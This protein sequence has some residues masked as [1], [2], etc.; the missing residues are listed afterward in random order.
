MDV[1]RICVYGSSSQ[2]T[3]AS[4][5]REAGLLGKSGPGKALSTQA[6]GNCHAGGADSTELMGVLR[7]HN[8]R[9][10]CG[11]LWL[12]LLS[13]SLCRSV[14][15]LHDSSA[16][17][18]KLLPV[19]V[20]LIR[21]CGTVLTCRDCVTGGALAEHGHVCVNGYEHMLVL[22]VCCPFFYIK[23]YHALARLYS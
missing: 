19:A 8:L 6:D 23:I 14:L 10:H 2:K 17:A 18:V 5:L 7:L 13:L 21:A 20:A 22:R 4:F 16:C 11:V 12:V 9:V 15:A 1:L 3:S